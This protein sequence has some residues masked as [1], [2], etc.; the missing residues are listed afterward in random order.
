MEQRKRVPATKVRLPKIWYLATLAL[1]PFLCVIAWSFFSDAQ[2]IAQIA[3]NH[4]SPALISQT[5]NTSTALVRAQTLNTQGANQLAAGQAEAAIDTWKQAEAAYEQAG[6]KLGTLG[7]QLNQVQALQSLGQYRRARTILEQINAQLQGLP[8][9]ALKADG[10]RSLGITRFRVGDLKEAQTVLQS[11]LLISQRLNMN[12]GRSHTLLAL[13]NVTRA[14]KQREQKDSRKNAT[15]EAIAFY[16]QAA[17]LAP[18]ALTRSQAKL[19]QLSLIA[20]TNSTSA[21][22]SLL[23]E[24]RSLIKNLPLNRAAIYAQVNLAESLTKMSNQDQREI[25]QLLVNATQ[26]A[27][28]LQD[29]RAEAYALGQLGHLYETRQQWSEAQKV[30]KQ[31]LQIAQTIQANDITVSW[32]WQLGRVLKQQG[33]IP[34]AIAAYN[35]AV[36]TLSILRGDLVAMNPEVQFSFRE[37]VEPVYRQLVQLLLQDNP[38]QPTLQRAREVIEAL[39]L[40]ELNNFFREACVDVRPE[41][42]D[43]VDRNAAVIYSILL[44][45]RLAVIVSLPGQLL[46]YYTPSVPSDVSTIEKSFDDLFANLNPFIATSDPLRPN[47]KL[48]DL[49]IRPAA[50]DLAQSQVKT[51][52]FVLD[53]VLR[54]VPIAA[55][56]DG[57]QY[58][59]EQYSIALSPG[60]QLLPPRWQRRSPAESVPSDQLQTLAGGVS[61]ARQGFSPLPGVV[62]EMEQISTLVPTNVLLNQ[63]FTRTQFEGKVESVPFP[64]VHLATHGQ[65][66][67]E[68]ENTFLLTWDGRINVKEFDQLL[69]GRNRRDRRPI[70]LLILSACQ[71]AAGDKRAALGLAGV[72]VRSGARSTIATLWSVQDNSTAL[73]MTQLYESLRKPGMTRAEALRQA[74]LTL[75]RSPDYQQPFYWA[76]F[77]LV[78]NWQ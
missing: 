39:Q 48:Y 42:I 61:E 46:R 43:Q 78:G 25:A 57:Q 51:L 28:K 73:L 16:Q 19:N 12:A 22:A 53:G 23:A 14:L 24:I 71:T 40:A 11:S 44:P 76:P 38:N 10:L 59:I 49:L 68:A 62:K 50:K 20:E 75:L 35:Q 64:I 27:R 8:D 6:D 21:Q 7:S 41:Q 1:L 69:E 37:Q 34:D 67:S 72:A 63:A 77:V 15:N 32:Q 58:L 55:L 65:F 33:Q 36:D 70:E 47:Q 60:L 29:S 9:S 5:P 30:T 2:G 54:G 45:D 18:D 52:V 56:H 3:P 31:A 17:T 66:S 4:S 13:G 74:Q 26:Q